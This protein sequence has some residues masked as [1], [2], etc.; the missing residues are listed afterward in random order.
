LIY[1]LTYGARALLILRRDPRS[2][3]IANIYLVASA[4]GIIACVVRI[5][6]AYV[7]ALQTIEGGTLVW[8]FACGCG[9]GFALT[10]AQSW[11]IKTK[12][13]SRASR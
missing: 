1:L 2:R 12:W 6:T 8:I 7:P 3:K 11:R 5:I 10:S 9:A 13:F 4:S